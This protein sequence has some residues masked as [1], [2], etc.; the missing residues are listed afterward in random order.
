MYNIFLIIQFKFHK[1]IAISWFINQ[2]AFFFDD[3]EYT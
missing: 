3:W 1:N 2:I